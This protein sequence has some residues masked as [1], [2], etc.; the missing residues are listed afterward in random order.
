MNALV[1]FGLLGYLF[2]KLNLPATPFLIGFI[3][4]RNLE[5]Y[6]VDA[7]KGSGGNLSVFFTRGPICWV[8]W[9]LILGS[10]AYAVVS[11]IKDKKLAK[12]AAA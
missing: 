2:I 8:L 7:L 12:E 3:L 6:F 5:K 1:I 4:G 9:L 11:E 10:I